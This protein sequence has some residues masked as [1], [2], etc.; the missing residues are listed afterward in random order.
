METLPSDQKTLVE[1]AKQGISESTQKLQDAAKRLPV[2][3]GDALGKAGGELATDA[4]KAAEAA[5]A[6]D[7]SQAKK[8]AEGITKKVNAA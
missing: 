3:A 6:G 5:V 1:R 2:K 8:L 7:L 4:K